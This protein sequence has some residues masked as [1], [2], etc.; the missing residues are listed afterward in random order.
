MRL[1]DTLIKKRD[2]HLGQAAKFADLIAVLQ[3]DPDLAKAGAQAARVI[4]NGARA[5]YAAAAGAVPVFGQ[6]AEAPRKG[7]KSWTPE[8]RAAAA[9]RMRKMVKARWKKKRAEMLKASRR[10]GRKAAAA[11]Q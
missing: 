9:D 10:G 2:H 11:R 6:P 3:G 1:L 4:V 8:Q 5:K 7:R